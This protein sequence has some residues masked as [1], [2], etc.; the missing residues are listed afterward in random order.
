M[1]TVADPAAGYTGARFTKETTRSN[2]TFFTGLLLHRELRCSFFHT[3][4]TR[5]I[6]L[7]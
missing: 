7:K 3:G 1:S 4:K 5:G 2:Q 6:C